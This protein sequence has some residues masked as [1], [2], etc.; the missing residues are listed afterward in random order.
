MHRKCVYDNVSVSMV[1]LARSLPC[2][3][4]TINICVKAPSHFLFHSHHQ[5]TVI[6][7]LCTSSAFS[8]SRSG[9]D[10][11]TVVVSVVVMVL[12][13]VVVVLAGCVSSAGWLDWLCE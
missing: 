7:G 4:I 6:S 5:I 8:G 11:L 1:L 2:Y 12:G 3:W 9:S 10:V 13:V